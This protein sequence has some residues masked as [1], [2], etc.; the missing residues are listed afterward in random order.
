M[1]KLKITYWIVNILFG[2]FL[3][4]SAIPDLLSTEDAKKFIC[5]QLHYP[6]Y[7]LPF[8]GFAKILGGLA[9]LLPLSS[10][11]KEGAY[12]GLMFDL[13]GAS[14]SVYSISNSIAQTAPMFIFVLLGA[15]AYF[16][17]RK[18]TSTTETYHLQTA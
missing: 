10:R 5:D 9:I 16:F 1:K 12:A 4:F 13:L 7:I 11:I 17:Y 3:I 14:R 18:K 8:L 6:A 2:G 15:A